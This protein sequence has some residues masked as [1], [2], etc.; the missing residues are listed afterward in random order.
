MLAMR[1]VND[2]DKN[3]LSFV[4]T[5]VMQTAFLSANVGVELLGY[6]FSDR[7]SRNVFIT[8][9]VSVIFDG[10]RK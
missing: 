6:D 10:I 8:R 2:V 5:S 9:L 1:N 3:M 7:S 4:L